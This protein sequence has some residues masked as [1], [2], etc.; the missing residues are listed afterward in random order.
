MVQC[1]FEIK[2]GVIVKRKGSIRLSINGLPGHSIAIRECYEVA[3]VGGPKWIHQCISISSFSI[4]LNGALR[5]FS[6]T[7]SMGAK[8]R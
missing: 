6:K 7:T 2:P 4:L 3:V 8:T 1:I 5:G